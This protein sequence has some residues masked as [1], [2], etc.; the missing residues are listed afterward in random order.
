MRI[1]SIFFLAALLVTGCLP[2]PVPSNSGIEGQVTIGPMCPVMQPNNQCPDQPYQATLTIQT[3]NGKKV[4]QFEA[5]KNG[6]FR[7]NL[8]PGDYV[9]HPES[10]NVMP[11]AADIPFTVIPGQFSRVDVAYESGI[12]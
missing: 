3:T 7:I 8:S 12:R 11:Y 6:R 5:D 9:L 10:P 2:T 4:A 1:I